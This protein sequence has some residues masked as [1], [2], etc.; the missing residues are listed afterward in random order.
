MI[1]AHYSGQGSSIIIVGGESSIGKQLTT[2]LL[3]AECNVYSIDIQE[4]SDRALSERFHYMQSDPKDLSQIGAVI[5][6]FKLDKITGLVCLS[7]SINHFG[8]VVDL[9]EEQWK[10]VFDI[11][12]KSCFNACKAFAPLLAKSEQSAIVN[13]SS[14]LAFGGQTNYGPYTNAKAAINAL[15]RT[16]ATEL[17]PQTRVNSIAPGAVDTP[18]IYSDGELRFD[19]DNYLNIVPLKCLA[20]PK[21][22]ADLILFLLSNSASHITGQCIHINGGAMMI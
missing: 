8:K 2:M 18:F 21:E 6:H 17:A 7:G 11:S 19:L 3:S 16:L 9:Q 10:E 13:M 5:E 15:T 22:I 12:F 4:H 14:G 1:Q 20:K